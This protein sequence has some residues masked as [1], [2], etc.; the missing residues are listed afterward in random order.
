[1][2]RQKKKKKI[3]A[4]YIYPNLFSSFIDQ[5]SLK[6]NRLMPLLQIEQSNLQ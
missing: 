5:K 6:N 2:V 1:M 4:R 3:D